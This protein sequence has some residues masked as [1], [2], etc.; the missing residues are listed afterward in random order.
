MYRKKGEDEMGQPEGGEFATKHTLW[1]SASHH[2]RPGYSTAGK[3]SF[4][5][6][7]DGDGK[8]YA[9]GLFPVEPWLKR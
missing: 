9:F 6:N 3:W 4:S 7:Q 5:N 2:T 1:Y 8:L